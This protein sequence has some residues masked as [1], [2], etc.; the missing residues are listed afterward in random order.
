MN[1]AT[2][3]ATTLTFDPGLIWAQSQTTLVELDTYTLVKWLLWILIGF[4]GVFPGIVA[5]MV[6]AERK[7]AARFQDR[8]GPNRVGPL[9]LLQPIADAVKLLTKES[10]VP[11]AA[12]QWVHLLAP[13]LILVSA[14]LVLAVIP[15][16]VEMAPVNL[17][18][19]M[20]YLVAVSSL[21]PLGIF[22]AGWSSRNKYSLLGAMR[23]VAQLVSYEIPQVISTIPVVLWAGSLSLVTIFDRQAEFGWFLLSPPGLLGFSILLIASIAEVNRTPFDLPEAESEIIAGYHTEYSGMRFGL[24]FLAEYMSVFGVSCLVTA[25]YLGGG[26]IVPFSDFPVSIL[27]STTFSYLLVNAILFAGFLG[28]VSFL[29]FVMFWIRATLPRM[30]VD[31]LMNFAWKYLVP[32]S[33][34]NV[35]LSAIWY[36]LVLRPGPPTEIGLLSG[37]PV[38]LAHWLL[39][40]AVT[41]PITLFLVLFVIWFNRKVR[42]AS[43]EKPTLPQAHPSAVRAA[44]GAM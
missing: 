17:P 14:M 34:A 32:L 16:G 37:L 4:F 30:R 12:D 22:L 36:E 20:V 3:W 26:M 25:L 27:G 7:V 9:G 2:G 38:G 28:K 44:S 29:I 6:W 40:W 35:L 24:F 8:I 41:G 23:S 10:I 43:E 31:R 1:A 5:Y 21:S 15:F 39:G 13:V 18:S 19:G 33:I 42:S 11:K